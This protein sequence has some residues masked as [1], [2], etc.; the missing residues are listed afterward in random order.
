M[1]QASNAQVL[2]PSPSL[3]A[4]PPAWVVRLASWVRRL[5]LRLADRCAPAP[6]VALEHVHAFVRTY[7]MATV[8][9]LGVAEHLD[10]TPMTAAELGPLVGAQP[11]VLHR[12]LRAAATFGLVGLDASGRFRSTRFTSTLRSDH[13][14]AIADWSRYLATPSLQTAWCDLATT[15]RTG[16][17]AFRRV[18]GTDCF[19]WFAAHPEEGGRFAAGLGGLTRGEAA[20]II[21]A[22][23]F[24]ERGRI[25]DVGGGA[26]VLLSEILRAR[27]GLAG[28]LVE[29][30]HMLAEA[31]PLLEHYAALDRTEM[32]EGNFFEP[33]TV[34]AD[35]YLL[36]WVLHDWD[37][38]TCLRILNNV[39]A[40]MPIGSRL[41]VI[42]GDQPANHPHERFSLIDAQMLITAEGG[43]ERSAEEISRLLA[44][45]GLVSTSCRH[46]VTG[47]ALVEGQ[48]IAAEPLSRRDPAR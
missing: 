26:G 1:S 41:V 40:A 8:A 48:R 28:T 45:S 25:C 20:A 31:R 14:W 39:A 32:V 23:P 44:R 37:D 9:E 21:A 46:T 38:D 27:P 47:L 34:A 36:K 30:P 17:D 18:H 22:Y 6:V 16:S 33:L 10:R 15:V 24:P 5:L 7:L 3:G 35:V 4:V 42:E 19:S 2:A 12:V 11:A 29:S 13:P 43:R